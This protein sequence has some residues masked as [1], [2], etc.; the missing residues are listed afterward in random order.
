MSSKSNKR[1]AEEIHESGDE[2]EEEEE[3]RDTNVDQDTDQNESKTNAVSDAALLINSVVNKSDNN[4]SISDRFNKRVKPS[5]TPVLYVAGFPMSM[6]QNEILQLFRPFGKVKEVVFFMAKC[7]A[8]IEME[9]VEISTKICQFYEETPATL[10]SLPIKVTFSRRQQLNHP[11]TQAD[12]NPPNHILIV[13]VEND[14]AP[15]TLANL[16]DVFSRSGTVKKIVAFTKHNKFQF[17]VEMANVTEATATKES[18]H[19]RELFQGCCTLHISFSAN[20]VLTIK[21]NDSRMCDFTQENRGAI[22]VPINNHESKNNE[23]DSHRSYNRVQPAQPFMQSRA[24]QFGVLINSENQAT[25]VILVTHLSRHATL[26]NLFHLFGL[27]GDVMRVKILHNKKDNALIQFRDAAHAHNAVSNLNRVKFYDSVL[28]IIPSKYQEIVVHSQGQDAEST[29]D[30]SRSNHHRYHKGLN[31]NKPAA[32]PSSLLFVSNLPDDADVQELRT[33][34]GRDKVKAIEFLKTDRRTAFV[35]FETLEDAIIS[36][37]E[38]HL[39]D[40]GG[41]TIRISFSPKNPTTINGM[42]QQ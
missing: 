26:E 17:L 24:S 18:L 5:P 39:G 2:E 40:F 27:Y 28:N 15:I 4:S 6:D 29:K 31:H 21:Q 25:P 14:T 1:K 7:E 8:F 19:G 34:L 20:T 35:R 36:L 42:G 33:F 3:E 30:F 32:A 12:T 9:S 10:H 41:R 13:V 23:Q 37:A 38:H 22:N 16:Y 11:G